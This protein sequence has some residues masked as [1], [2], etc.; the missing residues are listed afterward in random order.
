MGFECRPYKK[1]YKQTEE[2]RMRNKNV[3]ANKSREIRNK[4][5]GLCEVCKAEGD[6]TYKL[7]EVHHIEKIKDN[8]T[9]W[10]D[11]DNLICLCNYHH[12]LADANEIDKEYL[13]KL[14]EARESAEYP[15]GW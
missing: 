15:G 2:R 4:A 3:W 13:R 1:I 6:L 12:R 9:K 14:A 8:P 11:N 7:L 10:L 5:K